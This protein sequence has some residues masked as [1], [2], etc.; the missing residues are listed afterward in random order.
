MRRRQQQAEQ[1]QQLQRH[2][3]ELQQ[4]EAQKRQMEAAGWAATV[5]FTDA[6][7]EVGAWCMRP[8]LCHGCTCKVLW[9]TSSTDI[10]PV[11]LYAGRP[12]SSSSR[13]RPGK[14]VPDA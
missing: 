10:Y 9:R 12:P 3:E 2:L 1:Q 14:W 6:T 11:P 5:K 4:A 8:C 7:R 13:T